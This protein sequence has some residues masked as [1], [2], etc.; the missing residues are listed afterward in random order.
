MGLFKTKSLLV[1][2]AIQGVNMGQMNYKRFLTLLV[3]TLIGFSGTQSIGCAS[4]QKK[5]PS[6]DS[7]AVTKL[8]DA[9]QDIKRDVTSIVEDAQIIKQE[10]DQADA[11][12]DKAYD[13]PTTSSTAKENLD[14][15]IDSIAQ[16]KNHSD[17]VI[18]ASE[19]IETEI[20][21]IELVSTRIKDLEG[22]VA[23][24]ENIEKE[25]RAAAMQKLY[26]YITLFWVIGFILIAGGVAFAFFANKRLGMLAVFT[27]GLMLAFASASQYYLKEV[28]LVGGILLA[29]MVLA[30]VGI[31]LWGI[32]QSNRNATAMREVIEMIEI[33]KETMTDGERERIF[34]ENG[35]ASHVQ[36]NFTRELISKIKEK[37]G[38]KKLEKARNI[39]KSESQT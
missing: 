19:R 33:L 17:Q 1:G 12:I 34:G 3:V 9:A 16:I 10:A 21:K 11:S 28:A 4:Q 24:L 18:E 20:I 36:S 25:G 22:R 5:I 27:G 14:T 26:G 13:D 39:A 32:Y 7:G 15:A 31:L 6:T 38:F 2:Q 23:E 37:N 30:G 8:A 35:V 29:G